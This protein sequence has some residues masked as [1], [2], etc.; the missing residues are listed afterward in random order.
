MAMITQMRLKELL[1]YEPETGRFIWRFDKGTARA[2]CVAGTPSGNGY[3]QICLDRRIY[4][5]HRLVWLYVHGRFPPHQIDHINRERADNRIENLRE[6]TA[7]QQFQNILR[8]PGKFAVGV[9][10]SSDGKRW[11]AS[12]RVH[13]GTFLTEAEAEQAYVFAKAKFHEFQPTIPNRIVGKNE[14][15][16]NESGCRTFVLRCSE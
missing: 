14:K 3:I 4:V 10:K 9:S 8:S 13:L 1:L 12:I 7:A 2:G 5:A 11:N 15:F 16:A 6:A